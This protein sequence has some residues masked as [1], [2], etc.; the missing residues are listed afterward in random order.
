MKLKIWELSLLAA[1]IVAILWA[2]LLDQQQQNLSDNVI[3]LHVLA[4]SDDVVD[5]TLKYEVRDA[6]RE[7]VKPLLET[8]QNREDAASYIA[9]HLDEITQAAETVLY[10]AGESLPI[11]T[12]L[13]QESSPTRAYETFT[14]PAGF[15]HALRVEIGEAEGQNWWCVVFPPLCLEAVTS[16]GTFEDLGLDDMEVALITETGTDITMRFWA[17]ER[18]EAL[19]ARFR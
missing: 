16:D 14:L 8:A 17:L 11:R 6:V 13:T 1:F 5:Q 9:A 10:N 7:V 2:A 15:Y 3:R 18:I 12:V 4:H 19:R